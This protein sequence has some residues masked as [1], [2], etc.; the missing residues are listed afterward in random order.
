MLQKLVEAVLG[1]AVQCDD[2]PLYIQKIMTLDKQSQQ[3]MM[4]LTQRAL[5]RG[6]ENTLDRCSHTCRILHLHAPL[7][8][9]SDFNLCPQI[10]LECMPLKS[11][12][13]SIDHAASPFLCG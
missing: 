8:T 6:E 10:S 2:K 4:V 9:I 7:F 5:Q 1:C 13:F 11:A 12:S 3:D